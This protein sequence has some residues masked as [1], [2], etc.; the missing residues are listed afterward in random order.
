MCGIFGFF[1]STLKTEP[2][3]VLSKCIS[4]LNNRGPDAK[5]IWLDSSIGIGLAHSRLSIIDTSANGSQP[6]HSKSGRYILTFNGEIYNHKYLREHLKERS[7]DFHFKG[8]S[9][10]ETLIEAIDSFGLEQTL[11]LIKGMFAFAIWDKLT[12]KLFLVRDRLGEKPLYYGWINNSFCFSSELKAL[13]TFP[14]FQGSLDQSSVSMYMK[15]GYIPSPN[16]IFKGIKKLKAGQVLSF[17][18]SNN[19]IEINSYWSL[20][21]TINNSLSNPFRGTFQ[22]AINCLTKSID[23]TVKNQL[24]SDVP[25]GAFLSGGIDSSTVV[26]SM[27]RQ[28]KEAVKTFSI[29]FEDVSYDES[30][31][32]REISEYLGTEHT[33][34]FFSNKD[35]LNIIPNLPNIYDEPFTDNS[36]I[37][38]FL[39]STVASKNVKVVLTGDGADELFAG[40]NRYKYFNQIYKFNSIIPD[41]LKK[42]TS[43]INP[44]LLYSIVNKVPNFLKSAFLSEIS[45]Q[46]TFSKIEKLLAISNLTSTKSYYQELI[47]GNSEQDIFLNKNEY[48]SDLFINEAWDNLSSLEPLERMMSIDMLYYLNDNILYKV[49]RACMSCS[50][51]N[52]SPFLDHEIIKFA[53]SLPMKFKLNGKTTKYILRE[54]LFRTLPKEIYNRPKMGFSFP[55]EQWLDGPLTEMK[56][57]LLSKTYI[58]DQ[59]LFDPRFIEKINKPAGEL[60]KEKNKVL[61]KVLNFQ[62]WA[63]SNNL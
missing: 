3:Q 54:L 24:I 17:N 57:D 29:G 61:W 55:I 47:S 19:E 26:S 22:E 9:D 20:F 11:R 8:D 30:K 42:F 53:W 51:E 10:T 33:E 13:K 28:Q 62:N 31:Y 41:H 60:S 43:K 21:N 39:L 2:E 5:G 12:R 59:S 27:Q 25:L 34:I 15:Y 48:N 50:L 4:V 38:T 1:S 23:N 63:K 45:T 46:D 58:K 56:N 16:S 40:Y 35:C 18:S 44:N 14:G 32:A 36:Q 37:P 52:R 6:M 49:D 7:T